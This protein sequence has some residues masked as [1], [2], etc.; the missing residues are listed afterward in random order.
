MFSYKIK[1]LFKYRVLLFTTII[2]ILFTNNDYLLKFKICV[3]SIGKNENKYAREFAEHY[4]KYGVD[5]IF[6]YDNNDINGEN[7][8]YILNDYIQSSIIKII[9]IRGK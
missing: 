6:I 1:K 8:E 4:K 2:N 9:N 5:K 3:C 7:F